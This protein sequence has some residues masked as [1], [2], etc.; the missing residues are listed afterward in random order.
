MK[1]FLRQA[2][3]ITLPMLISVATLT[4]Q[5]TAQTPSKPAAPVAKI[6]ADLGSCTV[7]FRVTDMLGKPIYNAKVKTLIRYGF[8]NLRKLSL[9]AATNAEGRVQF[10]K[11]PDEVNAPLEFKVSYGKDSAIVTWDPGNNCEA[12]YPVLLY[13]KMK[14]QK[15]TEQ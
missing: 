12:E 2:L 5:T 14:G 9:E 6:S 1:A 7:E 10:V 11:M 13:K 3:W 4:A 15:N 8:M